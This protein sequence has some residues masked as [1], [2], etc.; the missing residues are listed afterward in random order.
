MFERFLSVERREPPD[1]DVDF[2]H[3]RREEVI[4]HVYE[5]YKR[6]HA[7]MTATVISYRS[8]SAIRDV[9]KVFGL[10]K[11]TL[12]ALTSSIWGWSM[13]GIT[14]EQALRAG[15]D[16]SDPR[17]NQALAL[18]K[19]LL[20]F[21]RHLSQ[22]VGGFVISEARLD[23][24]VPIENA[25]M[26]DRTVIEW[27]KDDLDTLNIL[28]VDVLGLGM[29][30]CLRRGLDLIE[31]HYGEKRTLASIPEEDPAVYNMLSRADSI[32]VFQVE[33]RAQMSMLPRLRPENFYDLVIEVAIVRPGPIQGDMVH[34]YLRRKE[35]LEKVDIPSPDPRFGDKNELKDV[36][37]RTLG[38]P[39]FQEQAMRIAMV[40]AKFTAVEASKL[41][42]SMA[43]FRRTGEVKLFKKR[44]VEGM[45]ERGYPRKFVENCF[46]QIEGFGEYGFPESHAASFAL[47]VY[48]SAWIKCHY[49][50]VFL[51]AL[52]NSQP[53][54]F[55]ATSQLV[56]DAQE[57]RVEVRAVDV[58]SS[59]WDC[60]LER[61]PV[62]N[63]VLHARHASMRGDIRTKCAVRLGFRQISGFS[64]D[65]AKKIES[66]RGS[67]FDSVRH[68]WLRT[69]LPTKAIEK[70]AHADTFNSVGLS[71]RDA[72]WSVKAL[73]KTGDKDNLP[74][75]ARVS[76]PALEP[77]A[78]LPPMLP[79]EQVIEDYRHLYLS[80]KAHP[81]SFLRRDLDARGIVRH[82]LLP[83]LVPGRRVT[84]GGVVLV[85]QRP[86]TGNA[87]FM[88]LED[89]TAIANTIVWP[90]KFEQ[91]RPVVMGARLISVTGVLQN[92][93]NVIH[94]VA[95]HFEDLTFLLGRLSE[96]GERIDTV[97]PPDVI[98]RPVYSRQRHPRSSDALVTMLKER[99]DA[100]EELAVAAHTA[101]VMP[102]GRNFH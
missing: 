87:I 16:A 51:A 43:T 18:A 13:E 12:D 55:Y 64:E 92:E 78:N 95:D 90:R 76:M 100:A 60:T 53:M 69:G 38:V 4:Q 62:P 28:K 59:N 20:D 102:K 11:D 10:S 48:A 65:W 24:I 45:C 46:K 49:P 15:L 89:E 36:L 98:K 72:L 33:S 99:Q 7:G 22:H 42:R 70:L 50:D 68:L 3:E 32:G 39:L 63:G 37:E 26:D 52:L 88:T 101:Q 67:G 9:G 23:E 44:F 74:L 30:S 8:R 57:H 56:C 1:I 5:H 34:P 14:K 97:S 35:G 93:K 81:V 21:P 73:Q 27:D 19:E 66:L 96:Q 2:E 80:L 31:S 25:A 40:A 71:R 79:G 41:R 83:T 84:I 29:L 61:T 75:F 6:R 86:G 82:E 47:L 91:Y 54:G 85:R 58:N 77:D 94:I 17:L